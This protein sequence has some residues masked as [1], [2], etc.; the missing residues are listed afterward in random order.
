MA[1]VHSATA[2]P[3]MQ[4]GR[5]AFFAAYL[6]LTAICFVA[7][8]FL[9]HATPYFDIDLTFTRAVQAFYP[10]WFD[11]LMRGVSQLGFDWKALTAIG[12]INLFLIIRGLRWEAIMGLCA[13]TGIWVLDNAAKGLV[14]RPRP[15]PEL[16]HV[17]TQL[18][19]PSFTSGHVTS[20]TVFYGF[21]W[22][23]CFTLL[24]HTW[25]RTLM[26]VVLATLI[27][28]VGLSRVYSGEHWLS[29]VVGSY[30]LGSIWLTVIIS[31]YHRGT[32][33]LRKRKS[34]VGRGANG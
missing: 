16:V 9:A 28:L 25:K 6:G 3:P 32:E 27:G 17:I 23:L 18:A 12:V 34:S 14:D 2:S 5:S 10:T 30:L 13:S 29:D 22:F 24:K 31:I 33:L 1:R 8:A 7:L 20:F 11:L 15:S 21:M 19:G 26:L 4:W